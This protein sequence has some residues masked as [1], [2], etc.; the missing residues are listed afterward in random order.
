MSK[1]NHGDHLR[2]A[3]ER[4]HEM[5]KLK[6]PRHQALDETSREHNLSPK[7]AEWLA[8]QFPRLTSTEPFGKLQ[9]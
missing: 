1:A 6:V 2:Q 7:D 4:V 3:V 5:L 9:P 8:E